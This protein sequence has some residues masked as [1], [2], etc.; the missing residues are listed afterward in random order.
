MKRRA[1]LASAAATAL[2]RPAIAAGT[3]PLVFV[4]QSNLTSLDPVWTAATVT[5][6]FALMVYETLYARD[7]SYTPRPLM[8]AGHVIEDDGK[9]WIMTLRDGL[10][11][12]D[13]TPVRAQDCVASLKRWLAR[14]QAST[15]FAPRVAAIEARDDR[16]L[17][18]RLHKPFPTLPYFLSKAQP[19]PV[20]VPERLAATDPYKQ[21]TEIVGC[22]PFRFV[23]DEYVSG[24]R[25][26]FAKFDKYTP[27]Q[28]PASYAAGGHHVKLERVE[29]HVI[30]DPSTAA[31]ALATGEV[32]WL[33]LPQ[34]DLISMLA[35]QSG[36]RTGQLDVFGTVGHL[37]PNAIQGP[38]ANPGVRRAML[39]AVNQKDEMI[40]AMGDDPTL[41]RVPMG[42][43]LPGSPSANDA[44]MDVMRNRRSV[45]QV[46]RMLD[47]AGYAGERLSFMHPTDQLAYH[48]FC[49]VAVDSFR[50]VGINVDD[51]LVDWGTILQRRNSKAPLDKGGWSLFPGGAPGGDLYDPLMA[52]ILRSNGDKAWV[53]WPN[54][55]KLE[56]AYDAWIDAETDTERR[57]LERDFQAAAFN[58]V[59][60]IPLGQYLPKAAWRS[61]VTGLLKGS[62]P[63][64]WEA[65]KA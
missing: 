44:G 65:E 43:F 59:P 3:K 41:W 13:G 39:A 1:F 42:Y 55:P 25:A 10:V 46:K 57:K 22:G 58:S 62:A 48:A 9:R 36:V 64:F 16:T 5:R 51:E 34:P 37:R 31:N 60:V 8:V 4:P 50:K 53:G 19:Q 30:P 33:E 38:T 45:D 61:N 47:E 29:W 7:L 6:N 14:D 20:I 23:A 56:A 40:A 2:A 24:S 26:V 52:G 32:D 28:E 17:V 35:G 21:L 11:F 63:V 49:T 18:W 12:H 54:D 27:R 15:T